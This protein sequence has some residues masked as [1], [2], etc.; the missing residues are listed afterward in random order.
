[1]C[2]LASQHKLTRKSTWHFY[3][4]TISCSKN[5]DKLTLSGKRNQSLASTMLVICSFHRDCY[6]YN[7]VWLTAN[8]VLGKY[9]L[10]IRCG[11]FTFWLL[12]RV[13]GYHGDRDFGSRAEMSL[14]TGH[15]TGHM[16]HR[17][18]EVRVHHQTTAW[19]GSGGCVSTILCH[20]FLFSGHSV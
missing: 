17:D 12:G 8:F 7:N 3:P 20:W 10:F 1:M 15:V 19:L 18:W 14:V 5:R 2:Y 13:F 16:T 4:G 6:K 11:I 9:I